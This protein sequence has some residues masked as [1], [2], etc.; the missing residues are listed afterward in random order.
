MSEVSLS[1][2]QQAVY[3]R[4]ETTR[5]NIFVTGRAGTGK[6]TLLNYLSWNTSKQLV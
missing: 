4:I 2:E 3:D 1:P 5:D 6:S